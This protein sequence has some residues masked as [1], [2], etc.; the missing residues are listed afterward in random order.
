LS[1]TYNAPSAATYRIG[2]Y[3][4]L[5]DPE[6]GFFSNRLCLSRVQ[7]DNT[8]TLAQVEVGSDRDAWFP[9]GGFAYVELTS[10]NHTIDIDYASSEAGTVGIRRARIEVWRQ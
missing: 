2:W 10:G 7:V 4:E 6:T 5:N 9:F 3:A 1:L 8:T